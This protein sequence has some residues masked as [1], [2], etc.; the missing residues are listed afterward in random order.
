MP[1]PRSPAEHAVDA[2]VRLRENQD[3]AVFLK[4]LEDR[5][6][7]TV[8]GLRK[9]CADPAADAQHNHLVGFA[10]G[11][12]LAHDLVSAMTAPALRQPEV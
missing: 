10:D 6:S 8:K 11:L 7:A 1:T 4:I 2:L 12:R 3:F 5:L 9:V